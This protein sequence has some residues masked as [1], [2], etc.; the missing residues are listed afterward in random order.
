MWPS[1]DEHWPKSKLRWLFW[2]NPPRLRPTVGIRAYVRPSNP[3]RNIPNVAPWHPRQ[4][5]TK[6][7]YVSWSSATSDRSTGSFLKYA[8]RRFTFFASGTRARICW[9][10]T[11]S[12]LC[13]RS[14]DAE[15][16][17]V[18]SKLRRLCILVFLGRGE[19][20]KQMLA[21]LFELTNSPFRI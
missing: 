8:T 16:R 12:R 17:H 13:G 2:R 21:G 7:N 15:L 10:S 4:S 14:C 3:C 9:V 11:R 5:G 6:A 1:L 20:P 18:L 19:R